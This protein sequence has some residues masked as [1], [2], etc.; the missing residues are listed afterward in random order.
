LF[1][2]ACGQ[3]PRAFF[4]ALMKLLAPVG[5]FAITIALF[6][7][8]RLV[9]AHCARCAPC[10]F[11]CLFVA[12]AFIPGS[13][14]MDKKAIP[15]MQFLPVSFLN[16]SVFS[17]PWLLVVFLFACDCLFCPPCCI[18]SVLIVSFVFDF[19]LTFI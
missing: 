17:C 14:T 8:L 3:R 15:L 6:C 18:D 1:F 11:V 10:L 4:S 2:G 9:C 19:Y 16:V 5:D 7:D 13:S 12:D